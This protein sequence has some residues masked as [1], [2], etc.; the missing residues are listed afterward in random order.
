MLLRQRI[1]CAVLLALLSLCAGFL[2]SQEIKD[3]RRVKQSA[4]AAIAANTALWQ[5]VARVE[6]NAMGAAIKTITRNR[7]G[8]AALA[9]GKTEDVRDEF[10]G[11]A[12]RASASKTAE[13]VIIA[14][15][16][17]KILFPQELEGKGG[18][19][20]LIANTLKTK[21]R[22]RGLAV[23]AGKPSFASTTPLYKGRDM[24]GVA[25]LANGLD[26]AAESIKE[27]AGFE[28]AVV[29]AGMANVLST[30]EG[31]GLSA[32]PKS[33]FGANPE[34]RRATLVRPVETAADE[35]TAE[36]EKPAETAQAGAGTPAAAESEERVFH[37]VALPLAGIDGAIVGYLATFKDVTEFARADSQFALLSYGG[38]GGIV[39]A[40]VR[41][42]MFQL[43]RSFRP[44]DQVTRSIQQL[45]EGDVDIDVPAYQ[46][47]DEIGALT[48][49]L[50][51]FRENAVE[52]RR[53]QEELKEREQRAQREKDEAVAEAVAAQET[54]AAEMEKESKQAEDRALFMRYVSRAYEHQISI[55][56]RT[57]ADAVS[58]VETASNTIRENATDTTNQSNLVSNAA[59][60]AT[61]N[62]ETVAAAAEELS[63]AGQE[64][65]RIVQ[66][67]STV[68]SSAVEE[69]RRANEG[70][71]ALDTAAEKIG[72]VVSLI[73]DIAS[74]T[75][76]LALNA[77]IEAARAGEAGKGF[78]VVATE[79]KSLAD[80]TAR[81]TEEIGAQIA[82]IQSATRHA[83]SSINQI[84]ETIE[85]IAKNTGEVVNAA[86]QQKIATQEIATSAADA[87][88]RTN[89]VTSSI[90][91][92]DQAADRTDTAAGEMIASADRMG[93]E[94]TNIRN[95]FEKFMEEVKS[96]EMLADGEVKERKTADGDSKAA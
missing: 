48:D 29:S 35:K 32:L 85:N 76:L 75:N 62:V 52:I 46:R 95:L 44:L 66:Q 64:I 28:V 24:I 20:P 80:Q 8:L 4:D 27:S 11:V 68:A 71:E 70:V 26:Q 61:S 86:E 59:G 92:V 74:Q 13:F 72:E 7:A 39:I 78:A 42:L 2:V 36:A 6:L 14:D 81:A 69:A 31:F 40:C 91:M 82:D 1:V 58:Q 87:A 30:T 73:N 77:T 63:A 90:Q 49:A 23:I 47:K 50:A 21:K 5:S 56:L 9:A 34:F 84:G 45:A 93:H 38:L 19:I 57:L 41:L 83:V 55:A 53:V 16:S 18:G 15:A 12:N 60:E 54:R 10:I 79:V 88:T 33:A 43:R 3:G 51:V 89:E 25:V 94:T 17:G 22:V 96:F 37:A 67:S 65:I